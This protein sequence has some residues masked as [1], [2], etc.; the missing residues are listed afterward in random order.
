MN[1]L[2]Y[3]TVLDVMY[4]SIVSIHKGKPDNI[5]MMG[6]DLIRSLHLV[7][8]QYE[9]RSIEYIGESTTNT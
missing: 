7:I 6:N 2:T 8:K 9:I 1:H 5:I 3:Y 4:F